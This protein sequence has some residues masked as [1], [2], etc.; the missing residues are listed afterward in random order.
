MTARAALLIALVA[1]GSSQRA[2]LYPAGSDKDDG[3]GDLAQKSAHL[4]THTEPEA[5]PFAPRRGRR[6]RPAGDPYGGDP[7]GGALYGGDPEL[8]SLGD[9]TFAPAW[10]R[11]TPSAR[12]TT[13][14]GLTGAIE[15]TVTWRGPPPAP[16][17]T[18]CG[19]LAN[20]SVR[21][22]PHNA[23]GGVLVYIEHV[24]VGRALPSYGRP[25]GVGGLIAKRGCVLSP[26]LQIVTP[27]PAG[28][29]IHGDATEARLLVTL[30]SGKQPFVLQQAGR[31]LLPAQPGVT[32]V[33]AD[34][35]SLGAAWVVA[36]DTP[37]Y[38]ITD[39]AGRFRIDELAPG[40][41]DV[42][43]WRPPLASAAGGKLVYGAPVITHRSVKI[44]ARQ[45]A[46]PARIDVALER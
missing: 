17:A 28:L 29:A 37:Y 31:V 27:L 30:P 15:G 23:V 46:R 41:Y 43:F 6:A 39:D 40:T 12:Y 19:S 10:T 5:S 26:A 9:A 44:D 11:V 14:A 22:G 2:R 1:C 32:R 33:E 34:D 45:P 4:F 8:G 20:P 7:Y 36:W 35:G 21:V 42:T 38:A 13:A 24:D 18:A 3:H 25:A 16:V